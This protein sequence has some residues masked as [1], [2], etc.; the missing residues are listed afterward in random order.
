MPYKVDWQRSRYPYV[1][2]LQSHNFICDC[3]LDARPW[4]LL[5]VDPLEFVAEGQLQQAIRQDTSVGC[6]G[7]LSWPPTSAK[8]PLHEPHGGWVMLP[9]VPVS[10]KGVK[11][12]LGRGSYTLPPKPQ[13]S[14]RFGGV[15]S[16]SPSGPP[17]FVGLGPYVP[18]FLTCCS[19]VLFCAFL[20]VSISC[21][22]LIFLKCKAAGVSHDSPRAQTCTFE[23]PGLQ[24]HHQNSTRRH[25]EREKERNG[26]GR[27]G[28]RAKFWS[29]Q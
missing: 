22:F 16:P 28:K 3:I 18:H 25:P 13:T 23:G 19:F 11:L 10:R 24:K 26:G 1:D 9:P 17:L 29:V 15:I 8:H 5:K 27:G 20:I 7:I 4:P 2:G 14:L 21:H 6:C 12:G